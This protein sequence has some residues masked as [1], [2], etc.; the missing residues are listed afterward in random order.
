MSRLTGVDE[1]KTTGSER[2]LAFILAVFMLIGGLWIYFEPL[3]RHNDAVQNGYQYSYPPAPALPGSDQDRAAI[4]AHRQD[5]TQVQNLEVQRDSSVR[6]LEMTREA[7][8]TELDAG[9]P[10][11]AAERAYRK[12]QRSLTATEHSL[13]S[14]R[15]AAESTAPAAN[16]AEHR[17][18]AAQR[19]AS[20]KL[21]DRQQNQR[22]NTFLLRL[23][24]VLGALAFAYWLFI[25]MRRR[26]SRYLLVGMSL[27]GF[28]TAQALVMA[29][30][31]STDYIDVHEIGPLVLSLVGIALT[32][33][34]I[35]AV[36]RYI[37]KRTPHRRVR[38]HECPFCGY[39]AKGDPYCEGCGRVVI[40][41]CAECGQRRRVGTEH[42]GACGKA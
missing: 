22:L 32:L 6:R 23:A 17:I 28:A 35:F 3:D 30:D 15:R 36:Q 24:Y 33:G 11:T 12:A 19:Q 34:A 31:Y 16:A 27:V 25:R 18:N 7:Y 26:R 2:F 37:A 8:R 4:T 20:K 39:P 9:H 29:T 13:S 1:V 14:A 38:K 40:A 21:N 42:C 41:A 5:T 10:A